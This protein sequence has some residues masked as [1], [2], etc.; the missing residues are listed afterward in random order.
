MSGA[1]AES[2]ESGERGETGSGSDRVRGR[3]GASQCVTG[4]GAGP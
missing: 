3:A 4:A 1:R 2:G